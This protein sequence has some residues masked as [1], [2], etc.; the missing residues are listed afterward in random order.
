MLKW[1]SLY[2][3]VDL[4]R[5]ASFQEKYSKHVLWLVSAVDTAHKGPT[6]TDAQCTMKPFA[7]RL[8]VGATAVNIVFHLRRSVRHRISRTVSPPLRSAL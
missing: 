6:F 5:L 8:L 1:R 3:G 4:K 2:Y 7:L